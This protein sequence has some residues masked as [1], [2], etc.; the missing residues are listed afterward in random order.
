MVHLDS[1]VLESHRVIAGP[2][3]GELT[4]VY[5]SLRAHVLQA[6]GQRRKTT[7][8]VTSAN[9]FEGKT[10]TAI[11]LAIAMA[12]DVR[13]TVLLV[14]A[15]LRT[16]AVA[17][18]LGLQ[19][20]RGLSDYLTGKAELADCLVRSQ[21][22]RLCILP[23]DCNAGNSAELLASPRMSELVVELKRHYPDRIVIYDLPPLLPSGDAIGFLPSVDA[24]LLVVR[25]GATRSTELTR[26]VELL[27]DRSLIGV[28]LNAAA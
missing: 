14:D 21:V 16:P 18:Y 23:A 19:T 10:L 3:F 25:D 11:N 28:V 4:D 22:E 13:Q 2:T 26:A 27:A 20:P 6:L 1:S 17:R 8:A 5:R 9:H 7:L 24:T 12:M 15:D